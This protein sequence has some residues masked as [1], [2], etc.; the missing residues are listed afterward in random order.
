MTALN[1]GDSTC[2]YGGSRFV[3]GASTTFACNGA[4][5]AM[6][7]PG[8]G[9]GSS[10]GGSS[11]NPGGTAGSEGYSFVGFTVA[12]YTGNLGGIQGAHAKCAAEFSGAHLCTDREYEVVGSATPIPPAGAWIDYARYISSSSPSGTPRDREGSYDCAGWKVTTGAYSGAL[13]TF[14]AYIHSSANAACGTV[15]SL[16]CCRSP[17]SAWFRGFTAQAYTGDLGGIRGA[18]AKC[19][20]EFPGAHLCTD[21]E[22]EQAGSAAP[23][24]PAGAW[25]DYGRYISSS[26]P[27]GTPRD[28]EGSYDCS[29]WKVTTGA[30]SGAIDVFGSYVRSSA[31]AACGTVRP[32]A[33]CS[34]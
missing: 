7:P 21:R 33:C 26:S 24:P 8:T 28:R 23:V 15:R 20:A 25:I 11:F 30:Y 13:D 1:P 9:G 32:L 10:D 27:S 22:Y 5:G 14:G 2:P 19:S 4:P 16:A 31:N 34:N 3:V 17:Q 6:G 29:G 18:H 12:T